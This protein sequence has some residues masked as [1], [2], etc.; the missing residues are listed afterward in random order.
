MVEAALA[1]FGPNGRPL[2]DR[3]RTAAGPVRAAIA[4][5]RAAEALRQSEPAHAAEQ[6]RRAERLLASVRIS[7]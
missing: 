5:V 1:D 6:L 7:G 3:V 2:A 4:Y